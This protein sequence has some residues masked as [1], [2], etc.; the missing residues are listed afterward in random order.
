MN[1]RISLSF[2]IA[3]K[4]GLLSFRPSLAYDNGLGLTPPMGWN[5]WNHFHCDIDETLIQE[6]AQVLVDLGLD[7]LGYRY[8]NLDDCWQIDRNS[9]GYI[10]EDFEKFPS[11]IPALATFVHELGLLFGLYSDAG[12]KTCQGRPGGLGYEINDATTYAAWNIDYLKYDNCF[13]LGLNVHVRYQRMHDALNQTGHPIFFSLCEWGYKDPAT[14]AGNVGNSW[15]T[16]GDIKPTWESIIKILD[17]NNQ[18]HEYAGPGGWNDPDML[19][20]G[21]GALT[22]AEQRAHFT[23]WCLMKA[24]LLLG[25][26]LR[27]Q[28]EDV[29]QIITNEELIAWDQDP[30]GKQGYKRSTH[31]LDVRTILETSVTEKTSEVRVEVWAGELSGGNTAVVLFNRSNRAQNITAF[32]NDIGLESGAWKHAKDVWKHQDLGDYQ[33]SFTSLV[34]SH[35]VVAIVLSSGGSISTN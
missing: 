2:W 34:E 33:D 16:T 11:G 12:I 10:Q 25:N 13:N 24:P 23:L 3:T 20:V 22:L 29:L 30:L 9:S 18:W 4:L 14:W 19:Q 26:D 31:Y 8:I 32:W 7:Q 6:T 17:L 15:R 27:T 28:S 5:S 35:D 21:N 1:R